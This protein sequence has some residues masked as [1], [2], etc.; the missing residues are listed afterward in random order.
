M[1]CHSKEGA[2]SSSSHQA[3]WRNSEVHSNKRIREN[4]TSADRGGF[5]TLGSSSTQA[6]SR[7]KQAVAILPEFSLLQSQVRRLKNIVNLSFIHT[8]L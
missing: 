7:T 5:L 2:S 6:T 1:D 8:V 4:G 3:D